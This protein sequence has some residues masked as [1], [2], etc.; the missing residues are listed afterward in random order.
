[1][2]SGRGTLA[3]LAGFALVAIIFA[4]VQPFVLI[5]L[6]LALLLVSY[7]PRGVR[8][9]VFV[10]GIVAV[11][12]VGDRSDLWWFER[13]WSL[14]LA[15]TF[16]WMAGWRP[17]WSFSAKALAALALAAAVAALAFAASPGAWHDIDA[18]M[19]GRASEAANSAARLLGDLADDAV[20]AMM[21]RVVSLQVLVFPAMLGLSSL[22][23]LGV[24][25]GV[26]SWL[27]GGRVKAF[28]GLRTFRFNDHLVWVWLTGLVMMLAPMGEL[29]DRIGANAVLFMGALYVVRG[30]AVV[31][32]VLGGISLTAGIVGGVVAVLIYPIL[33]VLLAGMLIVGLSDT[34]LNVRSRIKVRDDRRASR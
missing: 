8:E 9:A 26:H 4:V 27:S 1:V 29:G 13:G 17:G 24:A 19:L 31:V 2:A 32:S 10:A 16:V 28:A 20:Q 22:G 33:A 7:G 14:V 23:A 6:P 11:A 34:W 5:G 12:F 25:V 21:Q 15:G 30:F 3:P 18:L